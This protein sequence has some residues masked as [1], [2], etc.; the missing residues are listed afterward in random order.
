MRVP[1]YTFI[2]PFRHTLTAFWLPQQMTLPCTTKVRTADNF[3][4]RENYFNVHRDPYVVYCSS[5]KV[6]CEPRLSGFPG[7][8]GRDVFNTGKFLLLWHFYTRPPA[9]GTC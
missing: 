7:S 6:P 2:A 5:K 1:L 4:P 8:A 3:R 9:L